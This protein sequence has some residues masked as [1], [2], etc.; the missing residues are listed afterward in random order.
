VAIW[1][2]SFDTFFT[3]SANTLKLAAPR[4]NEGVG[5]DVQRLAGVGHLS[6]HEVV[7][8]AGDLIGHGVQQLDP[9]IQRQA[10]PTRR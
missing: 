3:T 1:K 6:G 10:R 5:H 2:D 4:G 9:L 7:E 8:A